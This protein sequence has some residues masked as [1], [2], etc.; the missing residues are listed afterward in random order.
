V[1][2]PYRRQVGTCSRSSSLKP[3]MVDGVDMYKLILT[4]MRPDPLSHTL[5]ERVCE[6]PRP[7]HGGGVV[8]ACRTTPGHHLD[9]RQ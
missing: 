8:P 3:D 6:A 1:L 4:P 7:P 9:R 5:W 2:L